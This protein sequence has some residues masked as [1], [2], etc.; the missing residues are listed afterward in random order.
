MIVGAM[1]PAT[2]ISADGGMN[3]LEA[4]TLAA[5]AEATGRGAMIVLNDR[6]GSAFY[7]TK[8]NTTMLDTFKAIEQGY[9]GAFF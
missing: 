1:R 9:L 5:T 2:A 8:T 4:I 6:I 3:L 7:T